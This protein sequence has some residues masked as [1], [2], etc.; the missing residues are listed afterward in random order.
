M[1]DEAKGGFRCLSAQNA[2]TL[3]PSPT[4]EDIDQDEVKKR[5]FSYCY[6]LHAITKA[7]KSSFKPTVCLFSF[8]SKCHTSMNIVGFRLGTVFEI[9][10]LGPDTFLPCKRIRKV[11]DPLSEHLSLHIC[12]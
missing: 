4:M 12:S 7:L 2:S 6:C 11:V 10:L 3:K 8:I 5:R 1:Q 9:N